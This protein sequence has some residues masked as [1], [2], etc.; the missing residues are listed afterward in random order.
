MRWRNR[1]RFGGL[2]VVF[3]F[4]VLC[5]LV[6]Q[7]LWAAATESSSWWA[8]QPV[9]K[10]VPPAVRDSTWARSPVDRFIL[11]KLEERGLPPTPAATAEVLLRRA[12][13]DLVGL[14]P[15]PAEQQAFLRDPSPAAFQRVVEQLLASPRYGERWARH[16]MDVVRYADTAGDNADYPVPEARLYRDYIIDSFNADKSYAQFVREQIAGDLLARET[17][18]QQQAAEQIVGTGFLALS[19]RYA[20]APFEFMHLTIEDAIDTTGRAFL[21]MTFRCARCHDHKYDPVTKEDYYAVYGIFASTRFPYAGS[22]EFQSKNFGRTGFVPLLSADKIKEQTEQNRQRVETLRAEVSRLEKE[23]ETVAA[24]TNASLSTGSGPALRKTVEAQLK[25]ARDELKRRDRFGAPP[26]VPLAYAVADATPVNEAVQVRGEPAERGPVV[27]RRAP[28][29]LGL[30]A[31]LQ[32]P[33]GTSGRLQLADWI[34]NPTN[35][36]TARVLVNRVWQHHFGQG[37]VGTPSN[38]GLRGEVPTHPELLDYLTTYFVEHGWSLKALHR[39]LLNSATWQQGALTEP[40]ALAADPAN[41]L[42]GRHSRRRLEAEAIRDAMCA[43]ADSLVLARPGAH[44]FPKFEDWN[45][46]QHNPFKAV[47][48]SDHRSVYLMTQRIQRHPF[49]SLFDAPD[50]NT[51]TDTRADSTVPQQALY[52]MNHPF[53]QTQASRLAR[54]LLAHPGSME[55]RIQL[56]S[57][58]AWSRSLSAVELARARTFL[59]QYGES[60][61]AL[62]ASPEQSHTPPDPALAAWTGYARVLLTA[63]EFF[64]VD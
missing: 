44:P 64:Y 15:P 23:K 22:E 16:W 60:S 31:E 61:A 27:P 52:L 25:S 55:E 29:S 10:P 57:Q 56:A 6:A 5:L 47:Y 17:T 40:A 42:C 46:T 24:K 36:L 26:E 21:G 35:P 41:H 18:L 38:F 51:S 33:E 13:F 48:S 28:C 11:A 12:W 19:R 9:K 63:N 32:I 39:L 1:S 58:L 62:P 14:P 53:V 59:N 3:G 7:A 4:G 20:T 54:R 2:S 50:A 8:F 45:W 43:V 49:L 34:A 30:P 37:L